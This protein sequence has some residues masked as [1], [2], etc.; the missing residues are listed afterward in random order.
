MLKV[1][2]TVIAAGAHASYIYNKANPSQKQNIRV[3]FAQWGGMTRGRDAG[4]YV[5]L[6]KPFSGEL[7]AIEAVRPE[8]LGMANIPFPE[9]AYR[10]FCDASL[11]PAD[12]VA[13]H[14]GKVIVSDF[15]Y[16]FS[17]CMYRGV[18]DTYTS[19]G[20]G[21]QYGYGTLKTAGFAGALIQM[22]GMSAD[23]TSCFS[24]R[25]NE[26]NTLP[27][28]FVGYTD[29]TSVEVQGLPSA[30]YVISYMSSYDTMLVVSDKDAGSA[31]VGDALR[32]GAS[33]AFF[34]IYGIANFAIL[35]YAV[36]LLVTLR[37]NFVSKPMAMVSIFL[38]G[39]YSCGI[40]SVQ[41][42]VWEPIFLLTSA[43]TTLDSSC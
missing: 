19:N 39:F 22:F 26:P 33:I 37:A 35:V 40:K 9:P 10:S 11:W 17:C 38:E 2:L 24:C 1:A 43:P 14:K 15:F 31:E 23:V 18:A 12:K 5:G 16:H 7:V 36:Y 4:T 20:G 13:P 30:L 6:S 29:G 41:Y 27:D 21:M 32:S 25:I 28:F 42:L 3:T 34:K 8:S